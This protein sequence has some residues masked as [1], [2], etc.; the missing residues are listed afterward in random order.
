METV[1]QQLGAKVSDVKESA[2]ALA[3]AAG[4]RLEDVRTGTADALHGAASSVRSTGRKS[5]ESIADCASGTA[6]KLDAAGTYVEKHRLDDLPAGLRRAV[7]RYPAGS[8]IVATAVGFLAASVF[9]SMTH[10]CD[11]E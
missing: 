10:S 2:E 8:L 3:R 4:K 1:S 7:R 6:D 11:R 5:A 9:R